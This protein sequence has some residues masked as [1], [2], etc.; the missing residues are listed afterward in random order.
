VCAW[1]RH[2][3]RPAF[4]GERPPFDD[5]SETH[6]ICLRHE[7]AVLARLPSPGFPGVRLLLVVSPGETKLYDHLALTFAT[8]ADVKV[9]VERRRGERRVARR[10]DAVDRRQGERR[11]RRGTVSALGYTAIRFGRQPTPNA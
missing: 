11:M 3:G 10:P 7:Q 2:E 4:L 9:I 5:P 1:C 8:V 6:G